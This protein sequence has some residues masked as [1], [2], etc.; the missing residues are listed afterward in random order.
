MD[1]L[2]NGLAIVASVPVFSVLIFSVGQFSL[3]QNP[4]NP[5]PPTCFMVLGSVFVEH[6]MF[7]LRSRVHYIC[8]KRLHGMSLERWNTTKIISNIWQFFH[9]YW[10]GDW[11]KGKKL[12]S[13]DGFFRAVLC[14]PVFVCPGK[15]IMKFQFLAYLWNPCIK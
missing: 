8:S 1:I 4:Q 11:K 10:I 9:V 6:Q 15:A 7:P 13:H 3:V 2:P 14:W 5:D 12:K